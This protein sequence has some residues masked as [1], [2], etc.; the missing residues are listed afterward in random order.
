[1]RKEE[2]LKPL[3][4][5]EIKTGMTIVQVEMPGIVRVG[6][7]HGDITRY[8]DRALLVTGLLAEC[9]LLSADQHQQAAHLIWQRFFYLK[10][11]APIQSGVFVWPKLLPLEYRVAEQQLPT[12]PAWLFH[13]QWKAENIH[14]IHLF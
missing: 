9:D 12:R 14:P 5:S 11:N 3:T 6:R 13:V 10:N 2:A 7:I 1:M 4:P 8:E